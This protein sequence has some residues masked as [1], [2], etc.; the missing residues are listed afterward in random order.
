VTMLALVPVVLVAIVLTQSR[1]G[2][3]A[4]S[5]VLAGWALFTRG[6]VFKIA[7]A[8]A[9]AIA[10][11]AL[12]PPSVLE[13][14]TT[15][16]NYSHDS[17]ARDRL[18]SWKVARRIAEDRPLTGVGPGNF[19]AVYDRYKNDFRTPHVAHNTPLQ[20]VANAGIPAVGVFFVFLAY[21]VLASA[22]L[23]SRARA[24][25]RLA[26]TREARASYEWMDSLGTGIALA[27]VGYIVG[28]QF[29][30]REDMD[31]FYL[32]AGLTAAMA[33]Q[34]RDALSRRAET[35]PAV[36]RGRVVEVPCVSVH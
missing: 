34:T 14:I 27:V 36:L 1:G 18:S 30:S 8:P 32:L 23:A 20:I 11:F 2:F 24:K 31:L 16:K 5:A 17:S 12:A 21:G 3:L 13:R 7:L 33:A 6:R 28:S 25:R 22:R 15:I 26:T 10:F 19:L 29:L 35:S 9:A 4:L